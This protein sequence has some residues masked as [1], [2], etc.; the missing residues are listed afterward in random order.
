M[1]RNATTYKRSAASTLTFVRASRTKH[2]LLSSCRS[3]SSIC[4]PSPSLT[5]KEDE[6]ALGSSSFTVVEQWQL[7]SR[8]W[9]LGVLVLKA[10]LSPY[11]DHVVVYIT[12]QFGML[13]RPTTA[14]SSASEW[15]HLT[16]LCFIAGIL[17][18]TEV[19]CCRCECNHFHIVA[20]HEWRSSE[21]SWMV[22]LYLTRNLECA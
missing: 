6:L 12:V 8:S 11:C 13:G 18:A 15:L 3:V 14:K 5:R 2:F 10:E 7:Q 22:P 9:C 1:A 17:P 16:A 20:S 4:R 21:K 19:L